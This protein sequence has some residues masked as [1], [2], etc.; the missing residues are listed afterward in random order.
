LGLVH[1]ADRSIVGRLV[2]LPI[3]DVP[4]VPVTIVS[5]ADALGT[6]RPV[7]MPAVVPRDP[8][9]SPRFRHE[10]TTADMSTVS[11]FRSIFGDRPTSTD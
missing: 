4:L 5:S 1:E 8:E 9:A 2:T 3:A 6:L 11:A 10:V 7:D